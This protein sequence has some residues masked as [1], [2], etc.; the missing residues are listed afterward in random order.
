VLKDIL[1]PEAFRMWSAKAL[2]IPSPNF[3]I[4][5][6][7][8]VGDVCVCPKKGRCLVDFHTESAVRKIPIGL[9]EVVARLNMLSALGRLE[10]NV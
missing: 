2:V 3:W 9:G 5:K 6:I 1:L 8:G 10:R 7:E 4:V